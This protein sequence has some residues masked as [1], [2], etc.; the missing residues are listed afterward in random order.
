VRQR[1]RRQFER[2]RAALAAAV[3]L[4]T[5]AALRGDLRAGED[6]PAEMAA[7]ATRPAVRS[8]FWGWAL[9][10][11]ALVRD[12]PLAEPHLDLA[13]H[14]EDVRSHRLASLDLTLSYLRLVGVGDSGAGLC[15]YI[16]MSTV[17]VGGL[18]LRF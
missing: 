18:R 12:L 5:L 16:G 15:A 17:S 2:S 9:T 1:H 8:A 13:P 7:P 10:L 14:V 6:Q 3:A 11:P 4:L